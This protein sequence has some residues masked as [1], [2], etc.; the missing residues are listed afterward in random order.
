M[1]EHRLMVFENWVLRK[2]FGSKR[3][4]VTASVV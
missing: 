1:K 4:E 3:K 2:I